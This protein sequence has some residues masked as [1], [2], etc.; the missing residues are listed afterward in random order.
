MDGCVS[1]EVA[2]SV[3]GGKWQYLTNLVNS[4]KLSPGGLDHDDD[5]H[6]PAG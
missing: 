3:L 2:N 1:G 4:R 6:F 5:E